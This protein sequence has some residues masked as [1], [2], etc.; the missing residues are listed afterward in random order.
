MPGGTYPGPED[1]V[2]A[3]LGALAAAEEVDDGRLIVVGHSAGATLAVA[4]CERAKA[5]GT[6]AAALCVSIAPVPDMVAGYE[7]RLSDEGDS[8]E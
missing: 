1:D 4:A 2:T 7:A 6:A 8:I 5:E 3:A